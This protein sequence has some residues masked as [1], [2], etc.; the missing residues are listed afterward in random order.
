MKKNIIAATLACAFAPLARGQSTDQKID[1]L[2]ALAPTQKEP[3]FAVAQLAV[4]VLFVVLTV[5][6]VN[7]WQLANLDGLLP[8]NP[9]RVTRF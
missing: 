9:M 7:A 3:P 8:R 6:A 2:H 1:A 4:L 5:M